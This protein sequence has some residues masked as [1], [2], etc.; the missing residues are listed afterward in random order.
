MLNVP[1]NNFSVMLGTEPPLP[2]YCKYFFWGGGGVGGWGKDVLLKDTT[3]LM[4]NR[5]LRSDNKSI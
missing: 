5:W 3:G 1:V 4:H 2:V